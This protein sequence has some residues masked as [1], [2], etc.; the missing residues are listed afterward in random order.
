MDN[1]VSREKSFFPL[2]RK[3][4]LFILSGPS[5][6]G[7][8]AVLNKLK[9][10]SLP[11]KFVVTMTTRPRRE[12]ERNNVDYIFVSREYF[13]ELINNDGLL[14]Y[15]NVYGNMY[16]VPR[17]QVEEAL[18]KGQDVI[19]KVDVQGVDNIKRIKPDSISIFLM[20]SSLSE[21]SQRLKQRRTESLD[22]LELRIKTASEEMEK[23]PE[24]DYAVINKSG[25]ID[26]AVSEIR[27]IITAE[28][29]RVRK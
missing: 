12:R 22:A 6:V 21:I 25:E 3:P 18:D 14:E 2:N 20:P 23:L 8:D 16:G 10:T 24:F 15:A 13:Q 1:T 17:V 11:L 5:G 27:S 28:K 19:V 4:S 29:C 9:G 26:K 7:K